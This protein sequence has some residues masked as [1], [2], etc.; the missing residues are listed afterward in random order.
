MIRRKFMFASLLVLAGCTTGNCREQSQ[1]SAQSKMAEKSVE[2]EQTS[3]PEVQAG[4][5]KDSRVFVYKYNGVLQCNMGKKISTEKMAEQLS[6]IKVYSSAV[7]SDGLMHVSVCGGPT[8]QANL[9]EIN[10]ADLEKAK[11]LG[12][13]L[14]TY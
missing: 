4:A 2:L 8:G 12:F 3:A 13:Q 1:K 10:G 9:Y 14:W 5:A 6:G 7:K 11:K